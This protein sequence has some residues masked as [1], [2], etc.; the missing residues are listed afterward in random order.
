VDKSEIPELYEW[1]KE[2]GGY[3]KRFKGGALAPWIQGEHTPA[4]DLEARATQTFL[5]V[6]HLSHPVV[7]PH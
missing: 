4:L 2:I 1:M 3:F 5:E 6:G 7:S